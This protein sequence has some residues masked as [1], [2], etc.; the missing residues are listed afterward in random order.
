MKHSLKKEFVN[1]TWLGVIYQVKIFIVDYNLELLSINLKK[2]ANIYV[3]TIEYDL[4][5]ER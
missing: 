5:V 3:A 4:G 2:K 1:R